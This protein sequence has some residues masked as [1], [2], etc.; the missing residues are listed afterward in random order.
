M[1]NYII[2][3]NF[4]FYEELNKSDDV[5]EKNEDKYCLLSK[6]PLDKNSVT[7]ECNHSFNYVPLY[8]EIKYVSRVLLLHNALFV[9]Q[10]YVSC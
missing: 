2:E 7:L 3:D 5:D 1:N 4:N 8:R 9:I 6:K 10:I